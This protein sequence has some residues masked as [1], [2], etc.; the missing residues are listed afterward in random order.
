MGKAIALY[1]DGRNMQQIVVEY[2]DDA[3]SWTTAGTLDLSTGYASLNYTLTG[4]VVE[5]RAGSGESADYIFGEDLV[6]SHIVL[7][8]KSR[9]IAANLSVNGASQEPPP[10][11]RYVWRRW[12]AQNRQ[13]RPHI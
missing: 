11:R 9:K 2:S 4:D 7:N 13:R 10:A 5:V 6:G 3:A 8:G 1:V 12:T